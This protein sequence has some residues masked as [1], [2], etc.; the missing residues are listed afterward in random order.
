M[1]AALKITESSELIPEH[2]TLS[3]GHTV[4]IVATT[5]HDYRTLFTRGKSGVQGP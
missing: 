1:A 4:T 3:L 5:A 2:C